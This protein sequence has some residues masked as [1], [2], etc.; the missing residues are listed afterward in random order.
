MRPRRATNFPSEPLIFSKLPTCLIG[1]GAEIRLPQVSSQVDFEAELV[2]VVG[3]PAKRVA[4][5]QALRYVAGYMCGND[6]TA[7]DW[8]KGK[9]GQQW[10]LGKS[11]DTFAPVGPCFVTADEIPD[12][13]SLQV[14][15][16]LNDQVMQEATTRDMTYSVAFLVSYISQVCT[17]LPGDLI[18]TGTPAGVGV[19]RD[20]QVFLQ[21]GDTLEVEIE[22]L[23]CLRNRCVAG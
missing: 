13:Q 4:E 8:Q 12:P 17:L 22:G 23:G 7:R 10:L 16:R 15:L 14:T 3:R 18:F 20:P 19:A 5:T 11:F 1:H 2:V 21:P 6:V 9:P